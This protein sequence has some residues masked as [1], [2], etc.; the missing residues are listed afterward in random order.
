MKTNAPYVI[1]SA[2]YG[3]T[4]TMNFCRLF[5]LL[6]CLAQCSIEAL[7]QN[8]QFSEIFKE[9][10]GLLKNLHVAQSPFII[11]FSATPGMGKSEVAKRLETSLQAIRLSSDTARRLLVQHGLKPNYIDPE[12]GQSTLMSYLGYSVEQLQKTSPNHL[13]ILDMSID[14]QY[15]LIA[16]ATAKNGWKLF[17]IR[18]VVPRASVEKRIC[19]RESNPE[20]YL[21]HMDTWYRDYNAFNPQHVD[22]VLDNSGTLED[23]PMQKL[24]LTIK[25]SMEK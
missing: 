15:P 18:L 4:F 10:S 3:A 7:E 14:R 17:V 6:L 23:L 19:D 2:A 8:K 16:S 9:H 13:F 11:S 24:L 1:I 12:T 21:K 25:N 22:F 5:F 20:A